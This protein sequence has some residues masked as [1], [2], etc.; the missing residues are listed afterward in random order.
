M[1][2]TI[3]TVL[4]R[5]RNRLA[6][7]P[8]VVVIGILVASCGGSGRSGG[9]SAT[10]I[11]PVT[12]PIVPSVAGTSGRLVWAHNNFLNVLVPGTGQHSTLATLPSGRYAASPALSPDGHTFALMTYQ[13]QPPSAG[14]DLSLLPSQGGD[15]KLLLNY[16][17][18]GGSIENPSWSPDGTFIYATV[19]TTAGPESAWI[20]RVPR[21]GGQPQKLVQGGD[22]ATISPD[23]KTLVFTKT[24]LMSQ[25]G[26]LWRANP[27]G[28]NPKPIPGT[29]FA[30]VL[31][32]IFSPDGTTLAFTANGDPL[33]SPSAS[34]SNSHLPLFDPAVASAHGVPWDAWTVPV[35]GGEPRRHTHIQEDQPVLAWSPDGRWLGMNGEL[36]LYVIRLSDDQIYHLTA[37][38]GAGLV[39]MAS[40]PS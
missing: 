24:D 12:V 17:Q 2:S 6:A 30:G 40:N 32:P 19:K 31:K 36:G 25:S 38:S 37:T 27:D 11:S 26:Q 22:H 1:Y 10:S 16:Q 23:G 28:S 29:R 13:V 14:A 7:V 15:A 4:P 3:S 9:S 35:T 39:W 8:L 34:I 33:T 20:I 5:R 21:D 18:A